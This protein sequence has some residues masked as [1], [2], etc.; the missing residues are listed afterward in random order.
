LE[1]AQTILTALPN[2]PLVK[3]GD[4]LATLTLCGLADAGIAIADDDILVFASKIVSKAEGREVQ[5]G[6]VTPSERAIGLAEATGK[7]A[8]EIELMLGEST[9]VV[10]ARPGL[11]ITRHKLGFISANAGLDHS[12]VA[13][14]ESDCVLLLPTDPDASA[15]R[16]RDTVRTQTCVKVGVII[17]DSHGR[18]H[19]MGTVGVAIGVAGLAALEDWRGRRD[20]FGYVLQHTEVG[21]ADMIASAATLL[22]GQAREG[23]PII[24]VRGVPHSD[25]DGSARD[26][27]RP[28]RMDLFL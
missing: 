25:G 18:P 22:L 4:D 23:R 26:L 27:V 6:G 2:V 15:A 19:R 5:L 8:R 1:L 14:G 12:N 3:P 17:A 16:I 10:R 20:L 28:K 9:E 11:I 13:G 7:D 24:H 21:L